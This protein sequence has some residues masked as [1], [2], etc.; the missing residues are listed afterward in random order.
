MTRIRIEDRCKIRA[1]LFDF[2]A[3]EI[4][5]MYGVSPERIRQIALKVDP[6]YEGYNRPHK[7]RE[8]LERVRDKL[9]SMRDTDIAKM[10]KVRSGYITFLRRELRIKKYK[11]HLPC[12]K[13][14]THEYAKGLCRSCYG[15]R[16]Y[17][18]HKK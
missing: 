10:Y 12:P 3:T 15:L 1:Y 7:N 2:T 5:K 18:R 13:C 11:K 9:G 17:R 6:F 16:L 4:A 14:I 8:I